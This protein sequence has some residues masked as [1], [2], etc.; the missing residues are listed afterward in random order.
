MQAEVQCRYPWF[1]PFQLPRIERDQ[2]EQPYQLTVTIEVLR[3]WIIGMPVPAQLW[4]SR[5]RSTLKIANQLPR[6]GAALLRITYD[7]I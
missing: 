7:P 6:A 1:F 3:R 4:P 2:Q 5:P